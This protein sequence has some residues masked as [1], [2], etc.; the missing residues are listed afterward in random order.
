MSD[1]P[2][3]FLLFFISAQWVISLSTDKEY[4]DISETFQSKTKGRQVQKAIKK[5]FDTR[6]FRIRTK[7]KF[8]KNTLG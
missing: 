3:K 7:Q 4:T 8:S 2:I 6:L 5:H 1:S